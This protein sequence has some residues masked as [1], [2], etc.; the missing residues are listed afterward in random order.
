MNYE[1]ITS[2]QRGRVAVITLNRPEKL[3]AWTPRMSSEMM[4][5]MNRAVDEPTIGAIVVT[6]AGRA[7]CAGADVDAVF[8]KNSEARDTGAEANA[9]EAAMTGRTLNWVSFCR[10]MRKPT[11]AA[12]NGTAVGIGVTM[13]LP[14][15]I[16]IASEEAKVGMFFV[17]MG[18][19]PE[20][21]SSGILPQMI[22]QARALEWCLSGRMVGAAEAKDAGMISEV[23][24]GDQLVDRAIA[25]G[26]QLAG[27]SS[28]SMYKIRQLVLDNTNESDTVEIMRREGVALE[29]AY[30]SWEHKEAIAA[31]LSKRPADFAKQA[32]TPVD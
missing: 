12:I 32:P 28:Y 21:A 29:G 10:S 3:N 17:R 5:A 13:I 8:R 26:E 1:Q 16:R 25:L 9:E 7:F 19:V 22:G 6:G 30:T 20:L 27:Q 2:E 11:I 23:V 4:D 18:L 14:M 15:D 31:F 24:A